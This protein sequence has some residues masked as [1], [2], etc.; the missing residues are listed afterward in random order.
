M[1]ICPHGEFGA[2]RMQL[3]RE[4]Q[5]AAA[6]NGKTWLIDSHEKNFDKQ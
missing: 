4:D 3:Q 5:H 1:D 2:V 6:F